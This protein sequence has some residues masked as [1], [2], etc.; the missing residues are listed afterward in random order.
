MISFLK[1]IF[2]YKNS[3]SQFDKIQNME[4]KKK[5]LETILNT[6]KDIEKELKS[7][8]EREKR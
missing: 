2:T 4:E 6:L 1:K 7:I 8:R 5:K 3:N